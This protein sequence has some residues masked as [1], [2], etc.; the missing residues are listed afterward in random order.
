MTGPI[1]FE[2]VGYLIGMIVAMLSVGGWV[3]N[4]IGKR[5]KRIADMEKSLEGQVRAN[6]KS[7]SEHKL[8]AAEHYATKDGLNAGLREMQAAINGRFDRVEATLDRLMLRSSN[9]ARLRTPPD[10]AS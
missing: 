6:E 3:L 4:L 10:R 8:F 9:N 5:D 1:T 2:A 7:L